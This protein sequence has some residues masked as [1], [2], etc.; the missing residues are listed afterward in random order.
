MIWFARNRIQMETRLQRFR[1]IQILDLSAL[2]KQL[3]VLTRERTR[4]FTKTSPTNG[5][6]FRYDDVRHISEAFSLFDP[7]IDIEWYF[8]NARKELVLR[9]S[10]INTSID[11]NEQTIKQAGNIIIPYKN[12]ELDLM[13]ARSE[14]VDLEVD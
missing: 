4:C 8:R 9:L 13:G 12:E 7:K 2:E 6:V 10:F 3:R 5:S 11:F 14:D 1:N